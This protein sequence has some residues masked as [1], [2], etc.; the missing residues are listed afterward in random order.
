[1]SQGSTTGE[2]WV[3]QQL[4]MW[5]ACLLLETADHSVDQGRGCQATDVLV[6]EWRFAVRAPMG[7]IFASLPSVEDMRTKAVCS[8]LQGDGEAG[9]SHGYG[10]TCA[11]R[12]GMEDCD[13]GQGLCCMGAKELSAESQGYCPRRGNSMEKAQHL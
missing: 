12:Q 3:A 5:P 8:S 7:V 11:K 6:L 10:C 1:M 13:L 4:V 2:G 9:A